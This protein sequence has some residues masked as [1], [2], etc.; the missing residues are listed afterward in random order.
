MKSLITS[1]LLVLALLMPA[2]ALGA[3]A[4]HY[5]F[6]VDGLYYN[7]IDGENAVEVTTPPT[8]YYSLT[9][10]TIPATVTYNGTTY[11]VTAI[12]PSAFQY[13][14]ELTSITIPNTVT[15]IGRFA[16]FDCYGLTSMT[17]SNSVT[18]IGDGA[19]SACNGLTSLAVESGNPNYDS[20]DNCNAIIETA[21][22]TLIAGCKNTVI[23]NTVTAIGNN[24]FDR[25]DGLT[26]IT[27]P[28]TVTSIGTEAF[29]YCEG[30]TSITI[31]NSVTSIGDMAFQGC[32]GMTNLTLGNSVTSIG[33]SAFQSCEALTSVDIPNSVTTVGRGA[34]MNCE[35]LA[36]ITIGASVSSIGEYAFEDCSGLSS[37]AV[38]SENTTYDSRDNC[39]AIIETASNTLI[40]GCK[41]TV[42]P[43]TVITIGDLAFADCSYLASVDIPNSVTSIGYAAFYR[44][45][46]MTSATIG[47]SVTTIDEA[48]FWGCV[49]M[50]S[51]TFGNSV[52]TIGE[53]AFENCRVLT[54]VTIPNSVTAIGEAAFQGC[55]GMTSLT[56][57]NSLT[58]IGRR[59]FAVCR[60]LTSVTIPNSVT[61]IGEEAFYYCE[62][63]ASVTIGSSVQS[64]GENVFAYCES[65][66]HITVASGNRTYDSRDN[67]N[68]IIET[69]SNTLIAGCKG[70][71]IPNS[72]III[73]REAFAYF[74][75][76]T[77][78]T[79]PN[80][81]TTIGER[82]FW[83]CQGLA[84]ITIPNS[85]I[86]IG[87]DAFAATAWYENQPDGVVYAGLVAYKYKGI[88]PEGTSIIL[89]D[90]TLGIAGGA[91]SS[92][93]N[94]T[95]VTIPNTV[96]TIGNWAF[97]S[98]N[99]LTSVTIPS[100]V[101]IIDKNPFVSCEGLTRI[102]V[103]SENTTYD[104]RNNCNA[105]VETA[106]NTLIAA[107]KR[108]VIPNTVTTIGY[109][110]FFQCVGPSSVIIPKSVTTIDEEAFMYC[111][112]TSVT[113]PNSVTSI[114]GWAF[115][116]CY[117]LRDAYCYITDL[118]NVSVG[119]N[120]FFKFFVWGPEEYSERTL[121]VLRG[122]A[123]A[124][125]ADESWYPYFGQI[126]DDLMPDN[127][128]GDV[129]G[130]GEV[131]IAD[132]N[133][134]IDIILGG[135]A[136]ILTMLRADVNGDEEIN[137]TDV[138]EVIDIIMCGYEGPD[139]EW[140]DL[141]L[142]SGTRWATMN[143]GASTPEGYGDYFAWGETAPK[144]DY[145]WSNYKWCDGTQ[146][147]L[148]KYCSDSNF[149]TVDNK[150]ELESKD[151][152]A[153]VNW[154]RTWRM[155]S[156][157]QIQ[158]LCEFCT[159]EWTTLNDVSG[160]LI[161]GPNGNTMFLPAAGYHMFGSLY[162]DGPYGLY[163]SRTVN[164]SD[165]T[166]TGGIG[167]LSGWFLSWNWSNSRFLGYPVRAVRATRN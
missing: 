92:C 58:T 154:G 121:H 156:I 118:S 104:S 60:S 30:L 40:A 73:G 33:E 109:G 50:T 163:W 16:F 114:G 116:G 32:K 69:A 68:A 138:N 106:S 78:I 91:F 21:S 52:T 29:C 18:F 85:V 148:T 152:A 120:S 47:N 128:T 15:T 89:N 26:S 63:L 115:C 35:G 164:E 27:I 117:F 107:C 13:D 99:G 83:G 87:N 102:V 7:Y 113:I 75:S 96:L 1:T 88:M 84:S 80:S 112:A 23:P 28:N 119:Y 166:L 2:T 56:L 155:P 38:A 124:Y 90:G 130:D 70:T 3:Y 133:A 108:T 6:Q 10:V 19:F 59:A 81:V 34:F 149:G 5:D 122:L 4:T 64:I 151:D 41:N 25:F 93:R 137:I 76:L 101:I 139:H 55:E 11:T 147:S 77:S 134:L 153:Y 14:R 111:E 140:V 36:S 62:S 97:S 12:G 57:G 136:D 95:N 126:V 44:C 135:E 43:N 125:Q 46:R 158:E 161:T 79:I 20:R 94:M 144:Q 103:A 42:I 72:V 39:N 24:A 31:P 65:L 129:N 53:G 48:A 9:S 150:V 131:T 67:C 98:C 22:N 37:M 160:M 100:S 159:S 162:N 82:A 141:G 86:A 165:P 74:R 49:S 8:E 145:S 66:A 146:Y 132:V 142:P 143:I 51:L 54:S 45:V 17:I 167:F 71:I 61:S 110:A 127:I 123:S 105:I 157:E